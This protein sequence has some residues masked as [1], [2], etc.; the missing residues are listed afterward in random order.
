MVASYKIFLSA[1][2]LLLISGCYLTFIS[3]GD[4]SRGDVAHSC[5]DDGSK[6]VC[7]RFN[8]DNSPLEANRV[9]LIKIGGSSIT[10]KAKKET[11]D[12]EALS[13]FS[14]TLQSVLHPDFLSPNNQQQYDDEGRETVNDPN[15][16]HLLRRRSFIVVHGAG[17]FGHHS[18]KEYGLKGFF[19]NNHSCNNNHTD[20]LGQD[21]T[22]GYDRRQQRY[23]MEG[24]A[25]TRL[26]VQTLNRHVIEAFIQ[27]GINAVGISPCFAIHPGYWPGHEQEVQE[28]RSHLATVVQGSLQAGLVPV[29][30][31]DACLAS[32]TPLPSSSSSSS[33]RQDQQKF[34][35]GILSGDT[36][37]EI[38]GQ[39]AWVEDVIF[40]T[41]VDGVFTSDPKIDRDAQ[42]LRLIEVNVTDKT[43]VSGHVATS[44]AGAS[45]HSHD[46]TGG[47]E[48]RFVIGG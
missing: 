27:A 37:M 38:L 9:T 47:L 23:G 34:Y 3:R 43:L 25:K 22:T 8:A 41:D 36:L 7:H 46:V 26:S 20:S 45:I 10:N 44:A 4:G 40:L 31:G 21:L 48:V 39:E 29:L 11:L 19:S 14:R 16:D 5:D 13:W 15:H 1:A 18:A 12:A 42:L 33:K 30:H 6:K 2:L 17:S 28:F 35:A 24:L 32:T